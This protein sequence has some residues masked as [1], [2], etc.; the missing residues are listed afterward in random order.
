[1]CNKSFIVS[2]TAT[3]VDPPVTLCSKVC[4]HLKVELASVDDNKA[5]PSLV[6]LHVLWLS[7]VV[8]LGAGFTTTAIFVVESGI[9]PMWDVG[10]TVY[11]ITPSTAELG[12]V[13]T[14]LISGVVLADA[15]VM[16]PGSKLWPQAKVASGPVLATRLISRPTP[17]HTVSAKA[18]V[19]TGVGLTTTLIVVKVKETQAPEFEVA[20]IVSITLPGTVLLILCSRSLIREVLFPV[21]AL[22]TPLTVFAPQANVEAV[23]AVRVILGL[24]SL[25]VLADVALVTTG[26]G[27]TTT[28][29]AVGTLVQLPIADI[30]VTLYTTVPGEDGLGLNSVS[31]IGPLP[32]LAPAIAPVIVPTVQL[33][34]P[35]GYVL[36][37]RGILS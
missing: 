17:L 8:T 20:L 31:T 36:D 2:V 35:S 4:T 6:S 29:M 19:I 14:S 13:R 9:H 32:P 21:V 34:V 24:T 5:M 37:A 15:P 26:E 25:Q 28:V 11:I 7:V 12:F 16:P 33:K 18:L 27:L 22:I 10:S 30:A 1:M 3:V 23:L